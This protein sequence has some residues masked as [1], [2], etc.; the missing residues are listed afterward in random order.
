MQVALACN[1]DGCEIFH[2]RRYAQKDGFS[3]NYG[4]CRSM[5]AP[6]RQ[7]WTEFMPTGS[8]VF[9]CCVLIG[10]SVCT[11]VWCSFVLK[12]SSYG[13]LWVFSLH[14]VY[15]KKTTK[16]PN[17]WWSSITLLKSCHQFPLGL[18]NWYLIIFF[19]IWLEWF[20]FVILIIIRLAFVLCV[21]VFCLMYVYAPC[22]CSTWRDQKR[23]LGPLWQL[24]AT[25][26]I[27]GIEPG[28]SRRAIAVLCFALFTWGGRWDTTYCS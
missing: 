19:D 17:D 22:A 4:G 12:N 1:K 2:F 3:D 28:P 20:S 10:L 13:I 25:T 24:L 5:W 9:L 21:W 7:S 15:I 18:D 14:L 16:V 23:A 8:V 6:F 27:L 11:A 26:W